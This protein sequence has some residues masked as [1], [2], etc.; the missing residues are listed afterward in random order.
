MEN[1]KGGTG[2]LTTTEIALVKS[3]LATNDYSNQEILGLINAE[4]SLAIHA[5]SLPEST[6]RPDGY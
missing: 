2:S 1:T 4:P 5:L 6:A 3:L